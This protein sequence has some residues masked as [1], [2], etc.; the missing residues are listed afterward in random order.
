V[1]RYLKA[2]WIRYI[3]LNDPNI[4]KIL[5]FAKRQREDFSTQTKQKRGVRNG[6]EN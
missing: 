2:T 5:S 3:I 1:K 4:N 6:T